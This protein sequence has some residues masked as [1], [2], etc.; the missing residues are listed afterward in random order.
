MDRYQILAGPELILK[1]KE[2]L[3]LYFH[4]SAHINFF[5]WKASS[6]ALIKKQRLDWGYQFYKTQP[7]RLYKP[8]IVLMTDLLVELPP[9]LN[10]S[11]Q[12]KSKTENSIRTTQ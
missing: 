7:N 8:K 4:T 1:M 9:S 5:R 10:L 6:P 11:S 3:Y 2:R 12:T